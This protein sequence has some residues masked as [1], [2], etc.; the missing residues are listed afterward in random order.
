MRLI[1]VS[2]RLPITVSESGGKFR[3]KESVGGLVTGLSSYLSTMKESSMD[4]SEFIWVGWP[5]LSVTGHKQEELRKKAE[6]MNL[7]PVFLSEKV[8]DRFYYGFC[9]KT[10]WPLFHYFT[11]YTVYDE[12]YW[13]NY[14]F[15][16]E[17]FCEQV[18]STAKP[19]DFIWI[20]DYHLM[21]LPGMLRE[22]LPP[23]LLSRTRSMTANAAVFTATAM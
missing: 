7:S 22:K 11:T 23:K 1:V 21:L 20:H 18:L 10:V 8:M 6:S 3:I 15:V 13:K 9:N 2:N 14:K 16:N 17:L 4:R 12:E 5:G 19:G